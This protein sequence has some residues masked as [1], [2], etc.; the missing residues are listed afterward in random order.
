MQNCKK[1]FDFLIRKEIPF[2]CL[3]EDFPNF[4]GEDSFNSD[5]AEKALEISYSLYPD[6]SD[7]EDELMEKRHQF[8][9]EF[10]EYARCEVVKKWAENLGMVTIDKA[11]ENA[12]AQTAFAVKVYKDRIQ[13]QAERF[14]SMSSYEHSKWKMEYNNKDH[15]VTISTVGEG[16]KTIR[17]PQDSEDEAWEQLMAF[18]KANFKDV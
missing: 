5:I 15:E 14:A 18:Q 9:D 4:I 11:Q 16:T 3:E 7:T 8:V 6:G 17:V 12:N 10:I 1:F 2:E 13:H